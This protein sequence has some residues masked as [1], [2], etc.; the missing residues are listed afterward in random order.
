[1]ENSQGLELHLELN[2]ALDQLATANSMCLIYAFQQF[3]IIVLSLL[4]PKLV[5][6]TFSVM[7]LQNCV[8]Y[9]KCIWLPILLSTCKLI[10]VLL[11]KQLDK[12]LFTY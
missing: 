8:S 3:Y 5:F 10:V 2:N 9:Q 7:E 12:T 4:P 11:R 6:L 1:M